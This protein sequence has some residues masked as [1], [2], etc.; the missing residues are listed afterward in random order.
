MSP[1][2]VSTHT[3]S[4]GQLKR[5]K[6]AVLSQKGRSKRSTDPPNWESMPRTVIGWADKTDWATA[7]QRPKQRTRPVSAP[8]T[9]NR[10]V[11]KIV[12]FCNLRNFLKASPFILVSICW[13]VHSFVP[14]TFLLPPSFL[15][16]LALFVHLFVQLV[17]LSFRSCLTNQSLSHSFPPS[18][19]PS[20]S[21]ALHLSIR[22]SG[23]PAVHQFH[24]HHSFINLF[25]I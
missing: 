21:P 15:S 10:W 11:I 2:A 20:L 9:R 23:R 12:Q 17:P 6:S 19:P 14:P 7:E 16:F 5:P 25:L 4:N 22:L 18:L 8:A 3:N 24:Q 13:L 1:Y